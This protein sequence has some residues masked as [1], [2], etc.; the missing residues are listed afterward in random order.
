MP[1]NK[2]IL[3]TSYIFEISIELNIRNT[4]FNTNIKEFPLEIIKKIN[5]A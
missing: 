2:G 5:K 1:H 3:A 4:E